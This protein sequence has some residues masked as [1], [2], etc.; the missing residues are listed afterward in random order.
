[1]NVKELAAKLLAEYDQTTEVY[2]A[3]D[4]EGNSF[5]HLDEV[6]GGDI[7]FLILYPKHKK[8]DYDDM[9]E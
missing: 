7:K 3:S 2:V 9:R 8:L 6:F 1:M 5:A 4:A